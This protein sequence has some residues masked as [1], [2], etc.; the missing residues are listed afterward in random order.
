MAKYDVTEKGLEFCSGA[1][2]YKNMLLYKMHKRAEKLYEMY[3]DD[4]DA[5]NNEI[6]IKIIEAPT[7]NNP[8][9]QSFIVTFI[10]YKGPESLVIQ[11]NIFINS[12]VVLREEMRWNLNGDKEELS[13]GK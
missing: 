6:N 5:E 2:M 10:V 1:D 7:D 8:M 13:D 3:K 11:A 4:P 9:R 12:F